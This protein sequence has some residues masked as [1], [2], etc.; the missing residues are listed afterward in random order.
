MPVSFDVNTITIQGATAIASATAG[1]KLIIDGCDATTTP[2]T[3]A[4]AVQVS[5]R[6]ASPASTTTS[7]ALAGS[8]ENHVYAYASFI[9]GET[10]QPG[11]DVHTF[12]LYG[13][14]EDAPSSVFVIA[15]CS[16][17]NPVHL[18]AQGDVVNRAEVQFEL[19]FSATDEVV[20]VADTSIY[21]TRGEFLLL[22][23][24]TVTTH[25]EGDATTGEA[26]TIYGDKTFANAIKMAELAGVGTGS[27]TLSS[28]VV[29]KN[30][31]IQLGSSTFFKQ[32][33]TK[34]VLLGS[35]DSAFSAEVSSTKISHDVFCVLSAYKYTGGGG[36]G[37]V[38]AKVTD[39]GN[40]ILSRRVVMAITG[41]SEI[42]QGELSVVRDDRD[43]GT[44]YIEGL[45]GTASFKLDSST[46]TLTNAKIG[47]DLIPDAEGTRS[48]GQ[49]AENPERHYTW[50]NAYISD[51]HISFLEQL[52]NNGIMLN[53]DILPS[54]TNNRKIGG[55]S[56]YLA[57]LFS[58]NV[59]T[60][61][62]LCASGTNIETDA[63]ILPKTT[64]TRDLGSNDKKFSHVYASELHGLLPNPSSSGGEPPVGSI[65]FVGLNATT[66]TVVSIGEIYDGA[67]RTIRTACWN[68]GAS[69]FVVSSGSQSLT[70]KYKALMD[71]NSGSD[72]ICFFL[73]MRVE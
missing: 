59:Y 52:D 57:S 70:K 15:I 43:S 47:C 14:M 16:S 66:N 49:Y 35:Y 10:G 33:N 58:T 51:I 72:G 11:G 29:P 21:T 45:V 9:Q 54:P 56:N 2:L 55:T 8:T 19:T 37:R 18:P 12:Y 40:G 4:Q 50:G 71:A 30:S 46:F 48:L 22:K 73:A 61:S 5:S 67:S 6:P 42:N 39:H 26:Q 7:I 62:I 69:H 60:S 17:I 38:T 44:T 24:R 27:I 20:T 53:G 65:I 64:A 63:T 41:V 28:N 1:N 31:D 3:K 32:V 34:K 36:G 23:N 13:H 25:T 68:T